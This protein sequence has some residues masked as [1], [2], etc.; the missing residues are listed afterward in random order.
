MIP[1]YLLWTIALLI[2]LRRSDKQKSIFLR[3][4]KY[5]GFLILLALAIL[6]PTVLPVFQFPTPSGSYTVGTSD[7]QLNLERDE[8]ITSDPNDKRSFM[9]KT[10]YPSSESG[11]EIDL[12]VDKGG[13]NGFALK[14]GMPASMLNYLDRVKTKVYRNMP[15]SEGIFHVLVFSHG[16]NSKANGYYA[17][18]SEIASQGYII[19]AVNYTYE[20]T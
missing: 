7:I 18:L 14:Y 20:S 11:K 12:Y 10:W 5:V 2:C 3:I 13:R 16:Y 17:L 6:I 4:S 8:I 1:F 19:F 15:V 9:I